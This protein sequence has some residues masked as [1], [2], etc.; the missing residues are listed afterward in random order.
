MNFILKWLGVKA[1]KA[2]IKKWIKSWIMKKLDN[3]DSLVQSYID[4]P[5]TKGDEKMAEALEEYA[6]YYVSKALAK[7]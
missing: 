1:L 3:I 5:N 2:M 7:I 6:K 4:D